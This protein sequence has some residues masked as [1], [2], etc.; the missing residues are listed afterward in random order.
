MIDSGCNCHV[1]PE[2]SDFVFYH[3]FPTP[4]YAKTAGQSQLIKIKGHGTV[5]VKHVLDN[6]DKCTLVL[7]EVLYVPQAST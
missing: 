2:K 6:G 5:Y 3:D 1:T 4:R 7:S